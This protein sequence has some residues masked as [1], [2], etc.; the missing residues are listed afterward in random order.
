MTTPAAASPQ[1]LTPDATSVRGRFLW[2]DLFVPDVAQAIQFYSAVTGW[3]VTP[4]SMGDGQS[5]YMM[6]TN[7]ETPV[8]GVMTLPDGVTADEPA[9]WW[10]HIGTPDVDATHREALALGGA[11]IVPPTDIPVVGRY[12]ILADP[13][14]A[15]FSIYQPSNP[16]GAPA[17][18]PGVGEFS[19]HELATTDGPAAFDFYTRLFGWAPTDAMEMGPGNVYQMFGQGGSTYGAVFTRP[20]ADTP[21]YWLLYVR[22]ADIARALDAVRRGG[23]QVVRGPME[24]P[25]GS[26]IAHCVDPQGAPFAL[27]AAQA[28]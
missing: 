17:A 26:Q 22:V 6:W 12:A 21:P 27:H 10:A 14:G 15:T 19:W 20:H 24:V 9:H 8:G 13:Q 18:M 7:G 11:S 4:W 25:G 1:P 5:P 23:G 28:G 2:Y 16:P 3:T